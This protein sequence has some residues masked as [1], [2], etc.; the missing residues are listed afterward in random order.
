MNQDAALRQQLVKLLES[1]E[2]HAEFEDAIDKFPEELRGK[3]PNGSPHSPWQLLEHMRIAQWD[4]LEFT[5]NPKHESPEF[6]DGYWPA[7]PEP[8]DPKAWDRA[9]KTFLTDRSALSDLVADE[10]TDLF[11][12]IPHGTGQTML[13]EALLTADHNAYHLGQLLLLRRTL[14]A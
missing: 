14:G 10:S 8:P 11:A 13:R 2:A 9:I 6:P 1:G 4:I 7:A 12:R 5:R 3:R